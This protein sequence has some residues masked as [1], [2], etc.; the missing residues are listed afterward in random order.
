[1][2]HAP[3]VA[4]KALLFNVCLTRFLCKNSNGYPSPGSHYIFRNTGTGR[5]D[6][7]PLEKPFHMKI[8]SL[9]LTMACFFCILLFA[10]QSSGTDQTN[11]APLMDT[12]ITEV[13]DTVVTFNP[14]T[15]E[16]TVQI[17]TSYDT[18]ITPRTPDNK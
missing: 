7:L 6:E 12:V 18:V 11:D 2:Q 16:E 8:F 5:N 1:M 9:M 14:E 15:Y 17:V 3:V 10:C 13:R 4:A